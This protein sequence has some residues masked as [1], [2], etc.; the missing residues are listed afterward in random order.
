MKIFE[1]L[2]LKDA[3]DSKVLKGILALVLLIFTFGSLHAQEIYTV[4]SYFQENEIGSEDQLYKLMYGGVPAIT[5][6]SS[7]VIYPTAKYP[8]IVTVSAR[9]LAQLKSADPEFR[10]VKLINISVEEESQK[11]QL[12]ITPHTLEGFL[13]LQFIL[14][15]SSVP[16]TEVEVR[17]MLSGFEESSL[18]VLYRYS[19][20]V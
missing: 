11:S 18:I 14:I 6:T 16:L 20:P 13:N 10:T 1:K 5:I 12:R 19:T 15:N 7:S 3:Q 8:Q 2:I 9:S 17:S 4:E